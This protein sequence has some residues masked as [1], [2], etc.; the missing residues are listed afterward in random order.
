[1]IHAPLVRRLVRLTL[2]AGT[3]GLCLP[4][5]AAAQ[6]RP[7]PVAELSAGWV[8]FADD[9][10]IVSEGLVGGAFRYYVHPRVSIGP[11]VV[12]IGGQNH[13]HL[14]VT[15][16]VTVD[17][18]APGAKGS[19]PIVPFITVGGGMFQTREEFFAGNF[20]SREGAFTAGGGVRA[21]VSDR[22]TLGVDARLGW[23][24]HVRLNGTIGIRLW[25]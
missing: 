1:M 21:V 7:A 24:T 25:D 20:T 5:P 6:D 18:R 23:E 8:G 16:N 11:E 15:G 22:V 4:D 10:A 17:L 12:Y 14:V 3:I 2:L 19:R 13:S 9:G